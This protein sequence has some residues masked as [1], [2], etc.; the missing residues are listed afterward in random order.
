MPNTN[1]DIKECFTKAQAQALG[2]EFVDLVGHEIDLQILEIIPES[3]AINYKMAAIG[4]DEKANLLNVAMLDPRDVKA[5]EALN[6]IGRERKLK[7]KY[8]LT[9]EESLQFALK[10]YANLK[11]EVSEAL[12]S[13]QKRFNLQNAQGETESEKEKIKDEIQ[14]V[15]KHAPVAKMVLVILRHAV[16][17]KASDIHIEPMQDISRV[18]Y[19]IDGSLTT[20]ITLPLYIHDALVARVKVMANLKIDET[21]VPQDGR[22]RLELPN[23][24]VEFRVSSLPLQ[25]HEKVV[26][27]VL[28]TGGKAPSLNDLGYKANNFEI[29]KRN[30]SKP[31]GIILI[32]GPTGSGKSMTLF[33]A[34]NIVNSENV[35]ISTLEDPVEYR[36][37]GINQSQMHP[38][39]G[40]SFAAGLRALLRQDPNII[41]VGEIR[42]QETAELAIHAAMTGHL[43]FSTLHTNSAL[44]AIPRLLDM[45]LEPFLLSSTLN[46]AIAQR[47]VKTICNE[48]KE[49]KK[50]DELLQL[51]ILNEIKSI[52]RDVIDKYGSI[53]LDKPV[54]YYGRG[55][56]KCGQTG[57]KGRT[58]IC[59]AVENTKEIKKAIN[60]GMKPED[61]GVALKAQNFITMKQDG[62]I[63]TLLGL[64]APEQVLAVTKGD[65]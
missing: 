49:E 15:L 12:K 64:T 6:Y 54:F 63:K 37:Q 17:G 19:R 42:D 55:C 56:A 8:F 32:T 31:N 28:D 18:R 44:G 29:I 22:I 35:N 50:I 61:V 24:D 41:M 57:F 60:S 58:A 4:I 51:E 62:L 53:S 36:L 34:L 21:R 46:V 25:D 33:S 1:Q 48:C 16:E 27:R 3:L 11:K 38:E 43:V 26:M 65:L 45:H 20:S 2:F 30:L 13:A 47:L 14:E 9:N 52:P 7:I 5:R 39:I 23:R 59:E 10:Q 40:F